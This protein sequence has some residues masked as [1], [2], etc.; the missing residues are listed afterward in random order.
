MQA[1]LI[2]LSFDLL[3]VGLAVV[4][5]HIL[6]GAFAPQKGM[7]LFLLVSQVCPFEFKLG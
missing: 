3:P 2:P 1:E 7:K 4:S 6:R 5:N